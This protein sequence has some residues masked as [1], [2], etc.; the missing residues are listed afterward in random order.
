MTELRFTD[1]ELLGYL[2]NTVS[3]QE[4]ARIEAAL[5]DDT[6]LEDRLM[7]LDPL[8]PVLQAGLT[9]LPGPDLAPEAFVAVANANAP[10]A[11]NSDTSPFASGVR[12]VAGFAAG[13]VLAGAVFAATRPGAPDWSMAVAQYQVLYSADTIAPLQFTEAELRAQTSMAEAQIGAI[14]LFD[15]TEDLGGLQLLRVQTL[16]LDGAPLI[17]MVFATEDGAPVALCLMAGAAGTE[18][19]AVV[20]RAGLASVAF[21]SPT[22][23]W[24]L[25]GTQDADLIG[26]AAQELQRRLS[27]QG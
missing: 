8:A 27:Y 4:A 14:R 23:R 26:S 19:T 24:V 17:Q 10:Q 5:A 9:L 11:Q 21:D 12:L 25:I 6:A 20:E 1:A 13:L 3:T 7:G 22:H 16:G 15:L 2:E 18:D